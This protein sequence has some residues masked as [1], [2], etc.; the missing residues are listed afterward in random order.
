V[1]AFRKAYVRAYPGSKPNAFAALGYDAAH[2][3]M[4][5][6]A[7]A[8]SSD[9]VDV[10]RA[11]SGIRRFQGGTGTISYPSGSRIPTKSVT[12]LQIEQGQRKLVKNLLSVSVRPP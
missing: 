5:A 1:V 12:I 2:L 10:S 4:A 3:L 6:V 7:E 8:G 11:L 9:P